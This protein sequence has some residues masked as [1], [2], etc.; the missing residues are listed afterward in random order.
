[1]STPLNIA[2]VG[3]GIAG[4]SC[5]WLLQR[6]GHQVTL[7]EQDNRLGGHSNTVDIDTSVGKVAVDTGFIV[8][9]ERCYPNLVPL[10]DHLGVPYRATTMSFG[11]SIN[12]GDLE[13]AGS[14]SLGTLFAQKRNLLRPRFWRMIRDLLRFYRNSCQWLAELD[15]HT[16]L[17][18]LLARE[19]FGPGFCDDHLL[20]MGAA[21]WS[22]PADAM[23]DY[24]AKAFLRFCD[25]H[26]LLQLKDR[27]QWQ[28]VVGGSR[29]YVKRIT[30]P[31]ADNIRLNCGIEAVTRYADRVEL[32]DVHGNN[33]RFDHLVMAGHADQTLSAL[34]DASFEERRLLGAFRYE[35]NRAVLHRDPALM[36]KRDA[37]W[38]CWNYLSDAGHNG[39]SVS[40]WMNA[41]Q[42][43]PCNEPVIV[44]LNPL[45]EP[46]PDCVYQSFNYHHPVFDKRALAAQQQ[47]WSLQG[48]NRTWYC[49]SYFGAGF[50]EDGAQSG[51]AV[52]EQ[53]GQTRRP[54]SVDNPN[55]RIVVTEAAGNS[56]AA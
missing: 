12:N 56:E 30:A 14:D 28:T 44:T 32:R 26:G 23:L 51:L 18:E 25:N 46:R 33:H 55:S 8:F 48:Q 37:A 16:T 20:P 3:S 2:V 13:Y 43:L 9:N 19:K 11:V 47:L 21:I 27:P 49:G 4:M 22:T 54:W 24:P 41:L 38:A 34:T 7:F 45:R 42:H 53:L 50:H 5:A 31:L 1:M 35:A 40:Y 52:A 10:F 15:E 36:P 17:G 29:E 39:L 6:S